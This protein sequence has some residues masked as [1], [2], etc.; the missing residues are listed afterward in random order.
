MSSA[1][2][3]R[4]SR[5]SDAQLTAMQECVQRMLPRGSA[6]DLSDPVDRF[7]QRVQF[8]DERGAVGIGHVPQ[9]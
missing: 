8:A 3:R 4:Q 1:P 9:A 2:D 6:L 5:T 7:E